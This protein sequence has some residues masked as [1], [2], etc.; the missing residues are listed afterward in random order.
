MWK[1]LH[2]TLQEEGNHV[3]VGNIHPPSITVAK[4]EFLQRNHR[5]LR[6]VLHRVKAEN[7]PLTSDNTCDPNVV[8]Q[9]SSCWMSVMFSGSWQ[10]QQSFTETG[11]QAQ[12]QDTYPQNM[13]QKFFQESV[14]DSSNGVG[15]LFERVCI[16][17]NAWKLKH[18]VEAARQTYEFEWASPQETDIDHST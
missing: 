14:M 10:D 13:N 17:W 7:M 8:V 18:R 1:L 15:E 6:H 12:V 9:A 5:Y 2:S 16:C 11:L 4:Q 3:V